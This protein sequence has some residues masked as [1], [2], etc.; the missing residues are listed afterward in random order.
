MN[1]P[2]TAGAAWK[3]VTLPFAVTRDYAE[4]E[5]EVAFTLG[6]AAQTVEI[7]GIELLN[8]GTTKKVADLPFT[9]IGYQGSEPTA[10]WRKAAEAR[11]E[12]IRKGDLTVVVKDAAGKPV[13]G[14]QVA[15]R[16]KK[17]AFLWGT[18]VN[19]ASFSNGRMAPENLERYKQEILKNFNVAVMENENKWPQW[20]IVRQP[21][22]HHQ[23]DRL[24]AR[25][26]RAGPRPQPGVAL[27]EQLEREGSAWTPRAI[28]RSW[29][30]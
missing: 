11:I 2:A 15:V 3:K 12:K 26:R 21:P 29:P 27:L 8:Y 25:E 4:G 6:M 28:L 23:G 10:A 13:P 9:R 20:S 5:A 16:M 22:G 1:A 30:R 18:A 19:A 17:H 7:G 24:A 14:A